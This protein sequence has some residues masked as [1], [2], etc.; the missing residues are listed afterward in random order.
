MTKSI[1]TLF[2]AIFAFVLLL[3]IKANADEFSADAVIPVSASLPA[4]VVIERKT[5]DA[6]MPVSAELKIAENSSGRY[7]ITYTQPGEY[8]YRVYQKKTDS[9]I[10]YDDA[11]YEVTVYVEFTSDRV[12]R[13][14]VVAKNNVDK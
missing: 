11:E 14:T 6:P 9:D 1:K 7:R 5:A 10:D 8:I 4:T 3:P 12:M 13:A 2:A